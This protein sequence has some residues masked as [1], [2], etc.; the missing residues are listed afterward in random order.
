MWLLIIIAKNIKYIFNF[1]APNVAVHKFFAD[2][3]AQ[4]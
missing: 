3:K 2:F 1:L 4:V